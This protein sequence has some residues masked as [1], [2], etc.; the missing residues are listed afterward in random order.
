MSE[1]KKSFIHCHY[2]NNATLI[3]WHRRP[4]RTFFI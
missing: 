1:L 2:A 3:F 4:K